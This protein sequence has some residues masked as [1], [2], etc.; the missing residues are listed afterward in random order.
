M[1]S[2]EWLCCR[3]PWVTPKHDK[4]PQ[5]VHFLLCLIHLRNW[6][7]QRLQF[8]VKVECASRSLRTTNCPWLGRGQLM[9]P[10]TKFWG[11]NHITGTAEPKVVKFCTR[12]G[13]IN[14]INRMTYHQQKGRGYGHVTVLKF[15]RLSWCS[16]SWATCYNYRQLHG[17]HYAF[18]SVT[19]WRDF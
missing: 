10:I 7:S 5:F 11:S 16:D 4:P 3:W 12:V 6:R 8:D 15:C 14:S 18:I 13:N 19:Q 9:W 1:R 17:A 2:I